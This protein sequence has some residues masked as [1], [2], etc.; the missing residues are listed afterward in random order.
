M[1]DNLAKI[2][3]SNC[4]EVFHSEVFWESNLKIF[5][6][7]YK[8]I[9]YIHILGWRFTCLASSVFTTLINALLYAIILIGLPLPMFKMSL[10]ALPMFFTVRIVSFEDVK[11]HGLGLWV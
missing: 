10:C 3:V 11:F 8:F 9:S 1:I 7:N 2:S 6:H 4:C 5:A